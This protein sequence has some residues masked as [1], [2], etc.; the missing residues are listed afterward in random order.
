MA[1]S[2]LSDFLHIRFLDPE[3]FRTPLVAVSGYEILVSP[4]RVDFNL[5]D[6][7]DLLL[8]Y[9]PNLFALRFS[10]FDLQIG[11]CA[12]PM[13]LHRAND[14]HAIS[15]MISPILVMSSP[16]SNESDK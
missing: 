15:E 1:S 11:C 2:F 7:G 12:Y 16:V 10:H 5:A 4:I 3:S 14:V 6:R 13:H 9:Q 8:I